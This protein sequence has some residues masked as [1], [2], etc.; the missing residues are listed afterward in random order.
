MAILPPESAGS[1][2]SGSPTASVS[3]ILLTARSTAASQDPVGLDNPLQVEYGPAQLTSSDPVMLAAD[4]TLTINETGVYYISAVLPVG[5]DGAAGVSELYLR[6][7]VN[8]VQTGGSGHVQL[9]NSTVSLPLSFN[10]II[11]AT[12]GD[13]LVTELVRDSGGNDSGGLHQSTPTLV[14]WNPAYSSVLIVSRL[15]PVPSSETGDLV[16][17]SNYV[18]VK[19]KADLPEPVGGVITLVDQVT[20]EINGTIDLG[21][22]TIELEGENTIVGSDPHLDRV[23]TNNA[24]QLVYGRDAGLIVRRVNLVNVGGKVFDIEDTVG[25]EQ[26]HSLFVSNSFLTNSIAVGRLKNLKII[27]IDKV[28]LSSLSDGITLEGVDNGVMRLTNNNISD[29]FQGTLISFGTSKFNGVSLDHN[30]IDASA[31]LV[32]IS[33]ATDSENI[34]TTGQGVIQSNTIFGS[35]TPS[36]TGLSY[37]DTRWQ[38]N[39]SNKVPDSASIGSLYMEDNTV[40]TTFTA[41]NTPTKVLGTTTAGENIQ[42]FEMP[43]NNQLKYIGNKFFDGVVTFSASIKRVSGSG[44]RLVKCTIYKN[45]SPLEGASQILEVTGREVTTVILGNPHIQPND[46]FELWIENTENTFSMQVSQ[47]QCSIT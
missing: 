16:T 21:T 28:A 31:G 6:S 18:L 10:N 45:G 17:R 13:V 47:L 40:A 20:Y 38:W 7:T 42:R 22:D 11:P 14:D 32:L 23:I 3:E 12:A 27:N 24:A 46:Y 29:T 1:S 26:T 33:G 19:S 15:I 37:K 2:S 30:F 39:L 34:N 36:I 9:D 41:V 8:G 4:G 44:N 43:T 5:R 35:N 25:N